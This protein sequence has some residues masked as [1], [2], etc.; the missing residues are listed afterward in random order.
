MF[1]PE[2][3]ETALARANLEYFRAR[4]LEAHYAVV[5]MRPEAGR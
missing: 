1:G 4:N 5:A 2:A 3:A